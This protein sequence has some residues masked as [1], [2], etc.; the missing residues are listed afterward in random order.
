LNLRWPAQ[1]GMR[2]YRLSKLQ[3]NEGRIYK[4]WRNLSVA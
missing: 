3:D 4:N 2:P 1:A